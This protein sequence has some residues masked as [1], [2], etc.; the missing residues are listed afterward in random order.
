VRSDDGIN[1]KISYASSSSGKTWLSHLDNTLGI[2][3]RKR[4]IKKRK[5]RKVIVISSDSDDID[6]S[7]DDDDKGN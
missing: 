3:K 4:I 6:E 1:K 2:N 7:D 5:K